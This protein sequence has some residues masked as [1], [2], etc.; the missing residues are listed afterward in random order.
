M[1]TVLIKNDV[2]EEIFSAKS[3][4]LLEG[5]R[6]PLPYDDRIL[7]A[8]IGSELRPIHAG[9]IYV[10][11]EAGR[12]VA[13]YRLGEEVARGVFVGPRQAAAGS[14]EPPRQ[15]HAA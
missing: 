5:S 2:S 6:Q 14:G 3:F 7:W 1:F 4:N 15:P 12:T 9:E 13:S 11:N 10:M 8:D